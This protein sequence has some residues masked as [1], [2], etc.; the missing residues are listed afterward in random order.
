MPVSFSVAQIDASCRPL[1]LL[2]VSGTI[3]LIVGTLLMALALIKFHA[4]GFLSGNAWLT[5]GRIRPAA[6]NAL[7]YGFAIQVFLGIVAWI[8]CRLGRLPLLGRGAAISGACLWNVAVTIG[9]LGILAGGTTSFELLEM[10][11]I[12]PVLLFAGFALVGI[13]A[14]VTFHFRREPRLYASHWF[15]LAGLFWFVWIYSAAALLL[16]YFPVRGVMQ[17]VVDAWYIGNLA[18][19]FFGAV[20]IGIILYFVPKL[21][22]RPLKTS[23]MAGFAFWTL[24]LFA[25]WTGLVLLIG[26]PIPAWML[27]ASVFASAMMLTPLIAIA[28]VFWS[29]WTADKSNAVPV[30]P[31]AL[32]FIMFGAK[33]YL[34]WNVANV[35]MAMPVVARV[36]HFT[37]AEVG[38]NFFGLYGFVAMVAFGALHYIVPR[39]VGFNW[40]SE[41]LTRVHFQCSAIGG[42]LIFFALAIG[43]VIQGAKMNLAS[44]DFVTLGKLNARFVG[45]ATLGVIILLVGQAAFLK[46]LLTL[47]HIWGEPA[48]TAFSNA[49]RGGKA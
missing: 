30:E 31:A 5:L 14:L 1:L 23:T 42:A 2:F 21:L 41:K 45:P 13:S 4:P 29:T 28:I 47:L 44:T 10:G 26:G 24:V 15:L 9:F 17:A 40:P 49:V 34:L 11:G 7:V 38:R 18:Q 33:A 32:R 8:L 3:W 46:N 48:R 22:N 19:M 35:L 43:G 20:G 16:V 39:L 36:T 6:A 27:S 37:W 25:P 12:V